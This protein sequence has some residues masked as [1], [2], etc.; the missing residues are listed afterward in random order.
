MAF[1]QKFKA[2]ME[3]IICSLI[4]TPLLLILTGSSDSKHQWYVTRAVRDKVIM[5]SC[6]FHVPFL[7]LS[8]TFLTV[9]MWTEVMFP[10]PYDE[11]ISFWKQRSRFSFAN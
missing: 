5:L 3:S 11:A 6:S 7:K 4:A 8:K 1:A 2:L 10:L 9:L